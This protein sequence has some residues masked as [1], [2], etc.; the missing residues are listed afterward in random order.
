M[1]TAGAD[2]DEILE[3][4]PDTS[5]DDIATAAISAVTQQAGAEFEE[6]LDSLA[7]LELFEPIGFV[8]GPV[9]E[10]EEG[11]GAETESTVEEAESEEESEE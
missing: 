5:F 4:A 6:M 11:T 1:G 9:G 10:G 2:F 7:G 8:V 3:A